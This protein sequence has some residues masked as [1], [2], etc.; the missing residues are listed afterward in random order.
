MKVFVYIYFNFGKKNEMLVKTKIYI[1]RFIL[2][3]FSLLSYY[4]LL[5]ITVNFDMM[6]KIEATI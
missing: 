1:F 5:L 3:S 4:L 6:N 2:I